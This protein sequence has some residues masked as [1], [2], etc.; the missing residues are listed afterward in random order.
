VM[1]SCQSSLA[2]YKM[3][4]SSSGKEKGWRGALGD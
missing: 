1:N 3:K 4:F 2:L